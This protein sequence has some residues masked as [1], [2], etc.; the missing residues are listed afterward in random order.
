MFFCLL[1][2]ALPELPVARPEP[3]SHED[4]LPERVSRPGQAPLV[5][6]NL[7]ENIASSGASPRFET[8]ED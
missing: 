7:L 1:A 4:I 5:L 2:A 8:P 3:T 6:Q